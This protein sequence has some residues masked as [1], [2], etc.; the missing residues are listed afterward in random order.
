VHRQFYERRAEWFELL[1]ELD[2]VMWWIPA[3]HI[4]TLAEGLER[5]EHLKRHGASDHAFGWA[6]LA[7]A[8]LWRTQRCAAVAAE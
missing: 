2:F 3:G 6:H 4:P 1:G 8:R 7:Q 5:L